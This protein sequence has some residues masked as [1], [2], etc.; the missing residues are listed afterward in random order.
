MEWLE[1]VDDNPVAVRQSNVSQ[2]MLLPLRGKP[3]Y[4]KGSHL[5][6]PALATAGRV[7]VC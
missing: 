5:C 3:T 1:R 4:E 2:P 7:G 6:N